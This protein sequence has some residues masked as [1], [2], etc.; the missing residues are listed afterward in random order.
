MQ[1]FTP[2]GDL[3]PATSNLPGER[4]FLDEPRDP[5]E[6]LSYLNARY[7]DSKLLR[8]INPDPLMAP[9]SPQ[10]LN[11][12]SYALNNPVTLN[13]KSGKCS[14]GPAAGYQIGCFEA[15]MTQSM[16]DPRYAFISASLMGPPGLG[17]MAHDALGLAAWIP[18]LS[19]PASALDAGLYAI[20]GD[21]ENAAWAAS[22][23]IPLGRA[24]NAIKAA[25]AARMAAVAG[26][27]ANVVTWSQLR[28]LEQIAADYAGHW[29]AREQQSRTVAATLAEDGTVWISTAG[30][31]LNG[32]QKAMSATLG[33]K[34]LGRVRG[35]HAEI[36]AIQELK[37]RELA[38]VA[39]GVSRRFCPG[40]DGC[41]Q[42]LFQRGWELG[43]DRSAVGP[44]WRFRR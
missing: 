41:A 8:F 11:A 25:R 6:G 38:P 15:L 18:P 7:Y 21:W 12:Y 10:T 39:I 17:R 37:D 16:S 26:D 31:E 14:W 44:G 35:Q 27:D 1:R 40:S 29:T 19:V 24:A 23:A 20:E 34:T 4:S 30:S 28:E 22:G 43:S 42:F 32:A 36:T 5:S 13:D 2:F 3:R 9:Y 33:H